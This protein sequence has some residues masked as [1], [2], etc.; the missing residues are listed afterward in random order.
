M[1]SGVSGTVRAGP[2]TFVSMWHSATCGVLAATVVG[3]A[4]ASGP[5]GAGSPPGGACSE[6]TVELDATINTSRGRKGRR[7]ATSLWVD[8][9]GQPHVTWTSTWWRVSTMG[10]TH[11]QMLRATPV[12]GRFVVQADPIPP[13]WPTEPSVAVHDGA[14]WYVPSHSDAEPR[15]WMGPPWRAVLDLSEQYVLVPRVGRDGSVHVVTIAVPQ[16]SGAKGPLRYRR[17]VDGQVVED[18]EFDW[19]PDAGAPHFM[20]VNERPAL[21]FPTIVASVIGGPEP[22]RAPGVPPRPQP[23]PPWV[24]L[25]DIAKAGPS[26]TIEGGFANR[27]VG[28]YPAVRDGRYETRGPDGWSTQPLPWPESVRRDSTYDSYGAAARDGHAVAVGVGWQ[29]RGPA[30]QATKPH[31]EPYTAYPDLRRGQGTLVVWP[32][33]GEH[34]TPVVVDDVR[35]R[36]HLRPS[37]ELGPDGAIHVLLSDTYISDFFDDRYLRLRCQ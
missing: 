14:N 37:V 27:G 23:T 35:I 34:A 3:C 12:R 7:S 25:P 5:Q 19:P 4:T 16:G 30:T 29:P 10:R 32:L 17:L 21:V 36:R 2:A 26:E 8:P 1:R 33:V 24:F 11:Q 20:L 18:R 31:G 28:S 13:Q 22:G 6:I 15:L 9:Q